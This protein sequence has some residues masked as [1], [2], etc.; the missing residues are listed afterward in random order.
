[1]L[2]IDEL[3]KDRISTIKTMQEFLQ[4]NLEKQNLAFHNVEPLYVH[5][6]SRILESGPIDHILEVSGL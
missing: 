3:K 6:A 4:N 2:E 5:P 1:L